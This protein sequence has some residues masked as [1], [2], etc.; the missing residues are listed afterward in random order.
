MPRPD[1]SHPANAPG[2]WYVD[3][4]CIGSVTFCWG[5]SVS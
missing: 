5:N 3:T 4:R 1:L 2:P